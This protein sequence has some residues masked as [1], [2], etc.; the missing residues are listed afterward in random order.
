MSSSVEDRAD[1][2]A[3][4]AGLLVLERPGEDLEDDR[5]SVLLYY[6]CVPWLLNSL[7]ASRER[8]N[9]QNLAAESGLC[10]QL[11]RL[12]PSIVLFKK[13]SPGLTQKRD[14]AK[15]RTSLFCPVPVRSGRESSFCSAP[16]RI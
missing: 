14:L 16:P 9:G 1:N 7:R 2:A 11:Y 3:R 8:L 15:T 6:A 10:R 5:A 13:N 12:E 4:A